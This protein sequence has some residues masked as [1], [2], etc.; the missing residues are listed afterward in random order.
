MGF[1][2][3]WKKKPSDQSAVPS[4]DDSPL[5]SLSTDLPPIDGSLVSFDDSSIQQFN[6]EQQLPSLDAQEGQAAQSISSAQGR[7]KSMAINI[8]TLDFTM[9]A[10]DDSPAIDAPPKPTEPT[11]QP[12]VAPVETPAVDEEDLNKLFFGDDW[13][14]PDWV[15]FDPYTEDTIEEPKPED[16]KGAELPEFDDNSP[17]I[18]PTE[19]TDEKP[20]LVQKT[21]EL[22][23]R[24]QAY[25]RVFVELD[26]MNQSLV[27]IDLQ[28]GTYEDMMKNEEPLL[29]MAKEQMEYLYKKLNNIDKKIFV[30]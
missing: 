23:I 8:P 30:Q 5:S 28:V 6:T 26:Q 9:P 17:M 27:K 22:F 20:R 16:F 12:F 21:M 15:T 14:E 24:G 19:P 11:S 13:K 2:S 1:M 4:K 10:S 7:N 29:V 3:F 25:T 18:A